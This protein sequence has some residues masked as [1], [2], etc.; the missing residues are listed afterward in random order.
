MPI[1]LITE[2]FGDKFYDLLDATNN[3]VIIVSPFISYTTANRFSKWLEETENINC[4]IITRFNRD[5]FIRGASSIEGLEQLIQ[6]GAKIYALQHL[7]SKLYTF[8]KQS[9]IM[10]S[11][12]FTL[13]GFFKNHELGMFM[14]DESDFTEQCNSY[15]TDLLNQIKH[16]GD[17]ELTIEKIQKE[18]VY[19]NKSLSDRSHSKVDTYNQIRW[20]AVLDKEENDK[21]SVREHNTEPYFDII[22]KAVKEENKYSY[23]EDTGIFLKFEG[24]GENRIL[25]NAIYLKRKEDHYDYLDRTYYPRKPKSVK[26]EDTI[27]IAVV[28][29]D[30]EGK[31][32]PIIIG[33]ATAGGYNENNVITGNDKKYQDYNGHYPYYIELSDGRFLN[34]PIYEGISLLELCNALKN[35]VYPRSIENDKIPIT[36]I[37]KR[38]HQKAHIQITEEA[39]MYLIDRLE[40]I[41]K[42]YGCDKI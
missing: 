5:E 3:E 9:A 6:A 17:W 28:S 16:T 40:T 10:G 26:K 4:I 15:V 23:N 22:D 11:A 30:K 18:K 29:K 34:R 14:E 8:D 24:T 33:Y 35:K 7:H 32:I 41:F 36:N 19:V 21:Q 1:T 12:N 25:N 37:L 42:K 38:H 31:D 20:G 39:K 2:N 27:F 13:K